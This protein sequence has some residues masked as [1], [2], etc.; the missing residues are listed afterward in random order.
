LL[1]FCSSLPSIIYIY[2]YIPQSYISIT[3]LSR[4]L[5]PP[6]V[7]LF[8][9]KHIEIV[10]LKKKKKLISFTCL[11]CFGLQSNWFSLFLW[12]YKW[13]LWLFLILCFLNERQSFYKKPSTH[14][15]LHLKP[16][17][18]LLLHNLYLF[19]WLV[20][21]VMSILMIGFVFFLPR[22]FTIRN[23]LVVLFFVLWTS[24]S[25]S[26]SHYRFSFFFFFFSL[27]LCL[28]CK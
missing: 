23:T 26:H 20:V 25:L 17:D 4:R 6:F 9:V 21:V 8:F 10:I 1:L 5:C 2:I 22:S 15:F 3:L 18:F 24:F 27:F 7:L 12:W 16:I 14:S 11:Y 28:C 19:L 13:W